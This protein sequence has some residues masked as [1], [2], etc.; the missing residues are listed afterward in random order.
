[1]TEFTP[2]ASLFGG[3][4]IGLS[5][6]LL[7]L[8]EG[9]IAGISG[10]A[11][12]LLPPYRDGAFL[13][14]FGFVIGLVAAPLAYDRRSADTRVSQTVSANLPL[15]VARRPARR[16]RLGLGQWLHQRPRRLRP[17]A[18]VARSVGRDRR[19]HGDRHRHRLR[20]PPRSSEPDPCRSSSIS[21]LA[22]SSASALSSRACPTRPRS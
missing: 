4:M 17:V 6:V 16:L 21:P 15:M 22:C 3:A 18:A 2:L 10:I 8:W 1:M 5:A 11:G 20:R 7:M 13:S 12:R 19:F 14:R 9:R